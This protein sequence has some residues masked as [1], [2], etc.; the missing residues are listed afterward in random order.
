MIISTKNLVFETDKT[1]QTHK[2][3]VIELKRKNLIKGKK[4]YLFDIFVAGPDTGVTF[5]TDD[6]RT[7]VY[8]VTPISSKGI[9][10]GGVLF[11]KDKEDAADVV[12][13][14]KA[15]QDYDEKLCGPFKKDCKFKFKIAKVK[16]CLKYSDLKKDFLD[17]NNHMDFNFEQD[18]AKKWLDEYIIIKAKEKTD[19]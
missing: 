7:L 16:S 19:V 6:P 11:F 17:T 3:Y 5:P 15:Y 18:K 2:G 10:D 12:T 9:I 14:A 8:H 4:F 13:M 1:Q